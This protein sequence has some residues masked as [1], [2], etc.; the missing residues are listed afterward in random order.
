MSNNNPPLQIPP[1]FAQALLQSFF[2]V[3]QSASTANEQ[4][5]PAAAPPSAASVPRA[6]GFYD[7]LSLYSGTRSNDTVQVPA[8]PASN[9]SGPLAAA[10][11]SNP[12][13]PSNPLP[14]LPP[15][16]PPPPSAPPVQ[17]YV[18]PR[19]PPPQGHPSISQVA[20]AQA[21]QAA[22]SL[23]SNV[24]APFNGMQSLGYRSLVPQTNRDRL[25][26]SARTQSNSTQGGRQ[27]TNRSR[28]QT[29]ERGPST[30]VPAVP[31]IV[32]R[33][34]LITDAFYL[35]NGDQERVRLRCQVLPPLLGGGQI[36]WH[37]LKKTLVADFLE[38][39]CLSYDL[40]VPAD[41]TFSELVGDLAT[42]MKLSHV[43]WIFP[44]QVSTLL[45]NV[46]P[47]MSIVEFSNA[48][49]QYRGNGTWMRKTHVEPHLSVRDIAGI[50]S[51][52]VGVTNHVLVDGSRFL[53][54]FMVNGSLKGRFS[55]TETGLG[56]HDT[57]MEHDCL[58][59]RFWYPCFY[60][61]DLEVPKPNDY[62]DDCDCAVDS[63]DDSDGVDEDEVVEIIIPPLPV[64]VASASSTSSTNGVSAVVNVIPAAIWNEPWAS[65]TEPT[66]GIT[67]LVDFPDHVYHL[68]YPRR[69]EAPWFKCEGADIEA[70][71]KCL[72]RQ[73]R[74]CVKTGDYSLLLS[75]RRLVEVSSFSSIDT[76][77]SPTS[78]GVGVEAELFSA[79]W[80]LIQKRRGQFFTDVYGDY[81]VPA[82][83]LPMLLAMSVSKDRLEE[84]AVFGALTGLMV[85]HGY[86]PDPLGPLFLQFALHAGDVKSL[87]ENFVRE[88]M[89]D[90]Y[91]SLKA[92]RERG[93]EG[94][95]DDFS[96][97]YINYMPMQIGSMRIR[98]PASHDAALALM[99]YRAALGPEPP[100]HPELQAFLHAFRLPSAHRFDL[101][102]AIR[103]FASGTSGYL[104][105][106]STSHIKTFSD[107]LRKVCVIEPPSRMVH[108]LTELL[109]RRFSLVD[110]WGEFFCDA[111]IPLPGLWEDVKGSFHSMIDLE[112]IEQEGFRSQMF[113]WSVTGS[114]RLR[115]DLADRQIK[116]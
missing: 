42:R 80:A 83:S 25:A 22:S 36:P 58:S 38:K 29:R 88:W 14:A 77:D 35:E 89:P 9:P 41:A 114:P 103:T 55:L 23:I 27:S 107:L 18:S 33:K 49:R 2:Q 110:L 28:Q 17:A 7:F 72:L 1:E 4:P 50:S 112:R 51:I 6:P 74:A 45:G 75:P 82:S 15:P 66:C 32:R 16:P 87:S 81:C 73:I 11:H 61:S 101:V 105:V 24:P 56:L 5:V 70:A 95:I 104:A 108:E 30:P 63:S 19:I 98:S 84:M 31:N 62:T 21:G 100:L 93:C 44:E 67:E 97:F 59:E 68:V 115:S 69:E 78:F 71:A 34:P 20:D 90:L 96:S 13:L 54:R 106:L 113:L 79:A 52:G 85:L 3:N 48:G 116:C 47:H 39:M 102:Q 10:A 92:F 60:G 46:L 91:G 64:H 57:I 109:G 12:A 53:I 8:V 76:P 40:D 26:S 94:N 37:N 43:G 86:Y 111:G 99:L 65:P